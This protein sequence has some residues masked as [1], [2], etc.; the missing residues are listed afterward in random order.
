VDCNVTVLA[1]GRIHCEPCYH[2]QIKIRRITHPWS[3][4]TAKVRNNIHPTGI[5]GFLPSD[6]EITCYIQQIFVQIMNNHLQTD[7]KNYLMTNDEL[8]KCLLL[9]D[10][11][12]KVI[13]LEA[14]NGLH[15]YLIRCSWQ[16]HTTITSNSVGFFYS[17]MSNASNAS[18]PCICKE[19]NAAI[20]CAQQKQVWCEMN[21][22]DQIRPESHCPLSTLS[23]RHLQLHYENLREETR[24]LK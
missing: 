14:L 11:N 5:L 18:M 2:N 20:F 15:A 7:A 16:E 12:I 3:F 13:R 4:W 24:M 10:K 6:T 21:L 19:C 17:T 23:P 9:L 8:W 1:V 22:D